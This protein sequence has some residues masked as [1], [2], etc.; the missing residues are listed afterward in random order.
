MS[1]SPSSRSRLYACAARASPRAEERAAKAG[2]AGGRVHVALEGRRVVR[3]DLQHDKGG[4][5]SLAQHAGAAHRAGHRVDVRA[6]S[7]QRCDIAGGA[8]EPRHEQE[9]LMPADQLRHGLAAVE[10]EAGSDRRRHVDALRVVIRHYRIPQNDLAPSNFWVSST[11]T[12]LPPWKTIVSAAAT[13]GA[14]SSGRS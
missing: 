14:T 8:G 7:G 5:V 2:A 10:D 1:T 6:V 3:L 11:A 13:V 12:A 4:A 9:I